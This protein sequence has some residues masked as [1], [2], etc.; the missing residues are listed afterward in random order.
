M[1]LDIFKKMINEKIIDINRLLLKNYK[2]LNIDEVTLVI[3][4]HLLSIASDGEERLSVN[5]LF[6][7]MTEKENVIENKLHELVA[8]GFISLEMKVNASGKKMETFSL[9]PLYEKFFMILMGDNVNLSKTSI[10]SKET[11]NRGDL[12]KNFEEEFSRTLSPI[13]IE[14]IA[15][16]IDV[17]RYPLE[18]IKAALKES[19]YYGKLNFKYISSILFNWKKNNIRT[20]NELN[21]YKENNG[22]YTSANTYK[23]E[24]IDKVYFEWV[25]KNGK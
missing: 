23:A 4:L 24:N 16:W 13:E 10:F 7:V 5:K 2:S 21:A 12:F 14:M 25:E 3:I 6:D 15:D 22:Q 19:V 8:T 11:V 17:E 20:L 1:N 18:L 9:A